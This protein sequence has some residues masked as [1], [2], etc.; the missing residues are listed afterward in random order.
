MKCPFKLITNKKV[1]GVD[2]DDR[3]V[4]VVSKTAFGNCYEEDC[5]AFDSVARCCLRMRSDI[6]W[7]LEV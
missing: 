3:N 7:D 5:M 4:D 2:C 1:R 6:S